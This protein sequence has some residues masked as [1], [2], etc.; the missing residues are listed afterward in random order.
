MTY[1]ELKDRL[2]KCEMTLEKIQDGSY[3]T[4]PTDIT[5][6]TKKLEILR[7]SL[8]KQLAEMDM[9]GSIA[10]DDERKAEKLAKKGV[11]V[12]LTA[13]MKPGDEKS[14]EHERMKK[15]SPKDQENIAKIKA[16]M[17][18][19]KDAIE[20]DARKAKGM[21]EDDD[22]EGNQD[23][24]DEALSPEEL[25]NKHAG[26]PMFKEEDDLDVGHQDDEPSML[27]NDV[28]DIAVYAAK[29]YKQ[30]HKYDQSDGEVDFPH[31]WQGKV[32]KA[33]EFISSAQHYLE[34]EEK[35]PALDQLALEEANYS[36]VH[37]PSGDMAINKYDKAEKYKTHRV[38]FSGRDGFDDDATDNKA[39][40][41]AKSRKSKS[42]AALKKEY[43]E[44]VGKMKQLAQHYKT[45]EGEAKAKIVAA[46]KQH[47][48]RKKELEAQLD[49]AVGGIGAGQ[50][51]SDIGEAQATGFGTG[52]GRSKTISKGKENNPDLKATLKAKEP[53]KPKYIMKN[54]IPHKLDGTPLKRVSEREDQEIGEDNE[55][56]LLKAKIYAE[57][58]MREY[59]KMYRIVSGN[60]GKEAE[61]EFKKIVKAKFAALQEDS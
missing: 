17:Q 19:E 45:A 37:V 27:K 52:Q 2:S 1:T 24:D 26:S 59:R 43:D 16:L 12:K 55:S 44:L 6:T 21:M 40:K 5:K 23:G 42:A 20:K 36:N 25:A 48:A 61:E 39:K 32:I 46:L 51:L 35:Q 22:I 10:T 41:N 15:L 13:E 49:Q 47:T 31:W 34:A 3:N 7:E 29:L 33:R 57:D 53:K 18:R 8:Q 28:Y 50:E 30:L 9:K 14:I 54:G 38:G 60:F 58:F 56:P 11:N 4:P